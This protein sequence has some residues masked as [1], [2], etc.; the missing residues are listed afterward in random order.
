MLKIPWEGGQGADAGST[1]SE[2][3]TAGIQVRGDRTCGAGAGEHESGS[4]SGRVFK[5]DPQDT[6]MNWIGM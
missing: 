2:E 6:R 3:A 4:D 5:V 1:H